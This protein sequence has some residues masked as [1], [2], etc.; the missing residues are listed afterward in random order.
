MFTGIIVETGSVERIKPAAKSI[1]VTIRGRKAMRGLKLG[2]SLAI[3][4]CCL[5]AVKLAKRGADRSFVRVDRGTSER[6]SSGNR[7]CRARSE[8]REIRTGR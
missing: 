6:S 3:N 4:G 1:E 2:D 8:G 7:N 5:T